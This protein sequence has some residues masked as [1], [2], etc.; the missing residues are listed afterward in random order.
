MHSTSFT[1][2]NY[3]KAIFHLSPLEVN[4]VSTN[5]IAEALQTKP[6]SVTD[7]LK[8]LAEKNL[9]NYVKYQGVTLTDKGQQT[10]INIIR[11]HRLWEVFLVD[12]LNF[13]WDEVH[14]LA[15]DLEHINSTKLIDSL[16][17]FLNFPKVDPHG[18][19]IPDR[20]GVL[21]EPILVPVSKMNVHQKGIIS[22]VREHTALFLNYLEKTGLMLGKQVTVEEV[23]EFDGSVI[24]TLEN[25]LL[26]ISRDVAKNILTAV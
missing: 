23:I 12:K 9:I 3:L 15:E 22:G 10:A 4:A 14:E 11:K 7:M 6:A 18:D 20:N 26:T 25:K 19:P 13:K 5:A 17:T 16:E 8:K 2:E 21:N 24:V 1:E